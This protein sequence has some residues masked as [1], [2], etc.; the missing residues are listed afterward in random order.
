MKT[1]LVFGA[2]GFIGSNLV[3][4]LSKENKVIA[5]D[6]YSREPDFEKDKNILIIKADINKDLKKL[7]NLN[8][9]NSVDGV[10]W[11]IGDII[12][13]EKLLNQDKILETAV[14]AV[15][16]LRDYLEKNL[17]VVLV[18]SAGMLYVPKARVT[19]TSRIEPWTWYGLQKLIL[20]KALLLLAKD[21]QNQN[22]RVLRVSSVY[23]ERQ[24]LH[25]E[26]GVVGKIIESVVTKKV[27]PLYGSNQSRRDFIYVQDL[28]VIIP[29]VLVK[30]LK[31]QIYNVSSGQ[32]YPISEVISAT[33]KISGRKIKI[34]TLSKRDA[35]PVHID[36]S[37]R[38][39]LG[40]LK[41]VKFTSLQKGL[42]R[43]Y[44]YFK[45]K[46]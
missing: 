19:E 41:G 43:T 27:F 38:R 15:V 39:L 42:R 8:K 26:Q 18:S 14:P 25:K 34:K 31:H 36:V 10:V 5:V 22:L 46:L 32:G 4:H 40:E 33:E 2:N 29:E 16:I 44:N 24:P 17:P 3:D 30:K 23:G 35:D 11:A 13:T 7:A 37:N 20:E 6:R 9:K 45:D 1:F 12:P 28:A 21:Y